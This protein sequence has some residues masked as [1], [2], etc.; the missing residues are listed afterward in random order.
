MGRSEA[1]WNLSGLAEKM[2]YKTIVPM[3][4]SPKTIELRAFSS[5]EPVL[6]LVSTKYLDLHSH[7]QRQRSFWS[8]PRI[9]TSGQVQ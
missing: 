9:E 8:A 4:S 7:P 2:I 6:L 5:P 3:D 1:L